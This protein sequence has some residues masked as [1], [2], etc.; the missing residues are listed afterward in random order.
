MANNDI[1]SKII[2]AGLSLLQ[3]KLLGTPAPAAPAPA[4]IQA[5]D[6]NSLDWSNPECIVSKYFSVNNCLLLHNWNRLATEADGYDSTQLLNLC[7]KLDQIREIL[8]FPMNIHCIFRSQ[9]Y[10][11]SQNIAPVHDVHSMSIACDFDCAPHLTIDQIKDILRPRLEELGI[12]MEF[13]TTSW[14]HVDLRAPGPS[15]REFHV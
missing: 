1:W 9:D 4:P 2:S 7:V 11:A 14:V 12:R 13:G 8:G 10:N 6:M 15:G 3:Q 5:P